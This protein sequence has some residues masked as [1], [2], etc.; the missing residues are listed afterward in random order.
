ML[1]L[2]SVLI[3]LLAWTFGDILREELHTGHYL[4]GIFIG[5]VREYLLPI[6]FYIVAALTAFSTGSSWGTMA[7]MF[8][9][10]IPMV[11]SFSQQP[12][13][14]QPNQLIMLFPVLGAV[15]SGAVFGDH[16][17]PI[18]DSTILASTSSGAY[19]I[20]H[21]ETQMVYSIPPLIAAGIAFVIAG[22][23]FNLHWHY[24]VLI[25]LTTGLL[26]SFGLHSFFNYMRK[27]REALNKQK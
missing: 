10:A 6:M 23:L 9:I 15:L 20:D 26:I 14:I 13:P 19:H 16:I 11:I 4:A 25:S 1:M 12:V 7:I 18:S 27:R 22:L 2:P 5:S 24:I 3:L 21:V 17:S 8:P